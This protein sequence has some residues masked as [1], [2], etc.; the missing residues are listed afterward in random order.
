MRVVKELILSYSK[1][2]PFASI[3]NSHTWMLNFNREI[4]VYEICW[5]KYG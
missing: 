3:L 1:Y 5:T 4:W 2:S